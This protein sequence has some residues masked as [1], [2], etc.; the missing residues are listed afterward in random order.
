L[1]Q[2]SHHREF[3]VF[4]FST[5]FFCWILAF[6]ASPNDHLALLFFLR[7]HLVATIPSKCGTSPYPNVF[8]NHKHCWC[9]FFL[10]FLPPTPIGSF[11]P[12]YWSTRPWGLTFKGLLSFLFSLTRHCL[13]DS[14]GFYYSLHLLSTSLSSPPPPLLSSF[15]PSSVNSAPSP[16][17]LNFSFAYPTTTLI[18]GAAFLAR[19]F[20]FLLPRFPF[21][22]NF[23]LP[24]PR[25]T[26]LPPFLPYD[27]LCI[28]SPLVPLHQ[29]FSSQ[30]QIPANRFPF[31]RL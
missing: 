20:P 14:S 5:L 1:E 15:P 2:D 6:R 8:G 9:S 12:P 19:V 27:S 7:I 24:H 28:F 22:N 10:F 25:E 31:A 16:L 17:S 23:S 11:S 13:S 3:L 29:M 30:S 18:T 21:F 4:V 26:P